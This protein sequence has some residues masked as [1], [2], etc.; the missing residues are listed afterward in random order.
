M[1]NCVIFEKNVKITDHSA[2]TIQHVVGYLV[3]PYLDGIIFKSNNILSS[4]FY[5]SIT[6]VSTLDLYCIFAKFLTLLLKQFLFK[7]RNK[8][9]FDPEVGT[10]N[11]AVITFQ[12]F[13]C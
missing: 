12:C 9:T 8:I 1:V 11:G 2:I 4:C 6:T 3:F 13:H 10:L 7:R 5:Y